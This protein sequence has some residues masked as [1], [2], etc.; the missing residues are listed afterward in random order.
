MPVRSATSLMARSIIVV[1]R[2]R[3]HSFNVPLNAPCTS[4]EYDAAGVRGHRLGRAPRNRHVH[5]PSPEPSCSPVPP[6]TSA[7]SSSPELLDAGHEVRCV[8]RARSAPSW[9]HGATVIR[10]DVLSG[11]GLQAAWRAPT[12]PTTSCTRWVGDGDFAAQ[13]R[14]AAQTFARRRRRTRA[15]RARL[16]GR[17]GGRRR[18]VLRAPA[19]PPRGRRASCAARSATLVYVRAAM[20]VGAGSTS[21]KIAARPGASASR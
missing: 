11:D 21:F 2:S 6:A 15:S 8:V 10:G 12:S 3:H 1:H 4:T 16:P 5:P 13:D 7:V 20:I 14:Q 18:R 9:P 17:A 19:Q